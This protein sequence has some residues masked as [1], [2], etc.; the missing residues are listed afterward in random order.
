MQA[1]RLLVPMADSP[2]LTP[3]QAAQALADIARLEEGLHARAGALTGVVW[4]LVSAG[5]FVTYGLAAQSGAVAHT[6]MPFLWLPWTLVGILLTVALWHLL[7]LSRREPSHPRVA[8]GW[9]LAT[10]AAF[11]VAMLGL[12]LLDLHDGAFVYMTAV[13]GFV[14]LG[15]LVKLSADAGRLASIPLLLAGLAM[16]AGA[17]AIGVLGLGTTLAAFAAAGVCCGAYAVA[18]LATFVRG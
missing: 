15:I 16:L 5:I 9:V 10:S 1:P 18:G 8:L 13:N 2:A 3:Q 6:L 17:V 7:A 14:A 11:V 12:Y 4:G